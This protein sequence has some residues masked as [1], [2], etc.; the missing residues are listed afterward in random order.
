MRTRR[1][2]TVQLLGLAAVATLTVVYTS[3]LH[4]QNAAIVSTTFLLVV[5]LVAAS[6]T[7]VAAI[8]TS[9]VAMLSFNFFFLP[10]VRTLTVADP[11][12]WVALGAFLVVSVVASNL[13][14]RARTRADEAQAR[15][16]ELA[17]LYDLSRDVLLTED[18]R[19]GIVAVARAIARR[20]DLAFAALALPG[21]GGAW[22]IVNAGTRA[23]A[24]PEAA[25][26]EALDTARQRLEFD[27]EARTYAGHRPLRIDDQQIH[28]V[29]L[30]VGTR[31]IGLLATER[32]HVDAGT[33]DAIAGL[34]ALAVER[35][36]MLEERRKAAH[37]RQ[38]EALKTTLLASIG[39]DLRTPLTAIRVGAE[40]LRSGDLPPDEREAQAS[41]VLSEV[42]RLDRLFQNLLDMARLDAGA[43]AAERRRTHPSEIVEAARAQAAPA[44]LGHRVEVEEG[45]EVAVRVDPRLTAA[46]LAHV[47]E[48]AAQYAPVGTAIH[49][50]TRIDADTLELSVH[51]E[52]PGVPPEDLPRIF[53]RF[54]RGAGGDRRPSGTGMGLWIARGLLAAQGGH[55]WAD[56]RAGGGA[57]FTMRVPVGEALAPE[58]EERHDRT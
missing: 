19:E 12:N 37:T 47:L 10:P 8:V 36:Q 41:I 46:A 4:I 54:Y 39:H 56:N 33:L 40:N 52:G 45:G 15:R 20:F 42:A 31:P 9:L 30:R 53:E 2:A 38:S 27:A 57:R 26:A 49:V 58:G 5:L 44:L 16:A 35:V 43:V 21:G 1:H 22:D 50:T 24:L 6:S 7:L 11:Q 55:I 48:N 51:D 34:A 32:G 25:L 3:V 14:A 18:S 28:L 13:S 23:L 29:P 17:R